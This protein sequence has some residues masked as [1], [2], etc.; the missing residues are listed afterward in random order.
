MGRRKKIPVTGTAMSKQT[1]RTDKIYKF[2]KVTHEQ[3]QAADIIT[4]AED[5]CGMDFGE[6]PAQKTLLKAFYGLPILPHEMKDYTA[7]TGNET[8]H[9][10]G[11]PKSEGVWAVG[12]RGGKSFCSALIA[13]YE[14][15]RDRWQKHLAPQEAGYCVIVCTRQKQAEDIIG[16]SCRRLLEGSR[17]AD[18]IRE[19]TTSTITLTNNMVI[20]S[21]PCSSTAFR[22]VPI[23]LLILDECC[24]FRTVGP[25]ADSVVYDALRPRLAQ[26]P[27]S[28]AL[29]ISTPA[30]RQGLMW[31]EFNEGRTVPSRLTVQCPTRL[32]NPVIPQAFIDKELVRDKN[33]HDRE[34]LALF[35]LRCDAF[36]PQ[37]K[38]EA[39]VTHSGDLPY[40]PNY[41][42][43][44][45]LDQSGLST[46][47]DRFAACISHK[48]THDGKVYIDVVRSWQATSGARVIDEVKT[49][50]EIYNINSISI[51]RYSSGWISQAFESQAG[52]TVTIREL[53][54]KVYQNLKSLL[55]K[56]D[57]CLCDDKG[58]LDG[59]AT[60][61]SFYG[62]NNS[63]SIFHSRT[64]EG[65]SDSA[66][67]CAAS[68]F[69]SS[70][71][72][73]SYFARALAINEAF[74][75]AER[76]EEEERVG[77]MQNK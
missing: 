67:A 8:V 65:H 71:K 2:R 34:F 52:L 54:P 24:H 68:V 56:G 25:K 22:G 66:D 1:S 64:S 53:L 17:I 21:A 41:T 29:K 48:D 50:C 27:Q 23:Y 77:R 15:T 61:E 51:D 49:L 57:L 72:S 26:F 7:M 40:N 45:G 18:M 3:L 32:L 55:L 62:A 73:L 69:D 11:R 58:L 63:M 4:F 33:N 14:S 42:Y 28:K 37:D 47:G 60:T 13:C 46:S 38:L 36:F 5:I 16:A 6:R 75:A 35:A 20:A 39:A 76:K 43:S 9:E 44:C 10:P 12:A 19:T 31:D 70:Q 74:F 30:A 59:L